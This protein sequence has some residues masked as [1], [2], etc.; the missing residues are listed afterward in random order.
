MHDL[1]GNGKDELYVAND[2]GGE[3]NQYTW[4]ADGTTDKVQIYAHPEGLSG[5]TWN[6]M[7]VPVDLIPTE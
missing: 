6:I 2:S 5:F 1:D 4:K 3:V 7:S